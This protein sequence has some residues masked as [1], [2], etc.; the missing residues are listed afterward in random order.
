MAEEQITPELLV[1]EIRALLFRR[2]EAGLRL[3]ATIDEALSWGVEEDTAANNHP[4]LWG[5]GKANSEK[6]IVINRLPK[7][8]WEILGIYLDV[9]EAYMVTL[10]AC[11]QAA[12]E[13]VQR[14][15]AKEMK[16][17]W[18]SDFSADSENNGHLYAGAELFPGSWHENKDLFDSVRQIFK[19]LEK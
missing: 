15:G 17:F 5:N 1:D 8:G 19:Q 16:I 3:L 2:G 10:P 12:E 4:P 11:Y 14:F 6:S 9:L 7:N 13:T 18:Q